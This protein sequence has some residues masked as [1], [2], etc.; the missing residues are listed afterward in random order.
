MRTPTMLYFESVSTD[1]LIGSTDLDCV[2]GA[3]CAKDEL[4]EEYKLHIYRYVPS[5][6]ILSSCFKPSKLRSADHMVLTLFSAEDGECWARNINSITGPPYFGGSDTE[7]QLSVRK[8]RFLV[9]INP[10]A[11]QG[12]ALEMWRTTVRTML[13]EANVDYKVF[14]TEGANHAY[15]YILS[16]E[17]QSYDAI[18]TLGGDGTLAEVVNGLCNRDDGEL[19]LARL[20]LVPLGA[21]TGNGLIK[22]ILFACDEE[23][24]PVNAL[25]CALKGEPR[26]FD[27]SFV[28]TTNKRYHSFLLLGWGL[29]A[30]IDILSE[31][32]RW[33][34]E[35]RLY[36]AAVY[37]ILGRRLYAGRLSF[38]PVTAV[39]E[40]PNSIPP[41][42]SLL[43]GE[44]ESLEGDFSAVF[45]LHTSHC[46]MS[47][48][49]SQGAE[50]DDG[51]FSIQVVRGATRWQLLQLLLSFDNGDHVHNPLVRC[52]KA[53]AYRLEPR[54]TE[55]RF[56]LDGELVEYGPIQ[57]LVMKRGATT[58]R[59]DTGR[60][61]V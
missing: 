41:L 30:D 56:T 9:V 14:V 11:G 37:F 3:I 35:L 13:T 59:L 42:G 20:V 44:W 12:N 60:R 23:Y 28:Q 34:G 22:S 4:K 1:K 46:S 38:L 45:V 48:H 24:S 25:F 19:A 49:S 21:G 51:V 54:T 43:P 36:A 18:L 40:A 5:K 55:G 2:I 27:L 58:F 6:S 16:F 33:M 7:N 50:L 17:W 53:Y 47:M 52:Y 61:D 31:S 15:L 26:V 39:R 57:G 29:V 32:M 8:R 10:K